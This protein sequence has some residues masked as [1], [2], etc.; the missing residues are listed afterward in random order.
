MQD[1]AFIHLPRE[2]MIYKIVLYYY[3]SNYFKCPTYWL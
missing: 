1:Y 2:Q 3:K